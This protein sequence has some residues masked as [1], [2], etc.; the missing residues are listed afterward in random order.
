[1][2]NTTKSVLIY[3]LSC[4]LEMLHPFMPYVTEEIYTN[5]LKINQ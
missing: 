1:M 4:I 5:Y 3:T 2:N